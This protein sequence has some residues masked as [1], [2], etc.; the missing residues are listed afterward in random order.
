MNISM[1][2]PFEF[3]SV[4][5]G[6][7]KLMVRRAVRRPCPE[8]WLR[9]GSRCFLFVETERNWPDAAVSCLPSTDLN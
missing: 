3:L 5:P 8:D 9:F 6:A 2:G 1:T 4:L 7:E